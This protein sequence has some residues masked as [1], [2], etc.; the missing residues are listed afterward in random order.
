MNSGSDSPS[1][2]SPP[3]AG[4]TRPAPCYSTGPEIC[5]GPRGARPGAG[6]GRAR[7][8]VGR[9]APRSSGGEYPAPAARGAGA[10]A[11]GA[12]AAPPPGGGESVHERGWSEIF[13]YPVQGRRPKP[14]EQGLTMVIDKGLGLRATQDLLEMA[15]DAIDVIKL[16]FGTPVLYPAERLREKVHLI[17]SY[18]I[19]AYPGGT[20]LEVAVVQGRFQDFLDEAERIGF[21][22][23]EVSDG[24]IPMTPDVRAEII[25]LC[26]ERGFE[27]VSEVGKK[28]PADRVPSTNLVEQVAADLEAGASHVIIEG[29]ESGK[30]VV[31]YQEDGSI[32]DDELEYI[33][34]H[35]PDLSRL[36]WEAP[37]KS[38][39]Q[40]LI[41]RFGPN[42]NLGNV[43]PEDVLACEALRVGLRGDTLRDALLRHPERF[44]FPYLLER[45]G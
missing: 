4:A 31:I 2:L 41:L 6:E 45:E 8:A 35:V 20:L 29:R 43:H 40:D 23:L 30:G 12:A 14:R 9:A 36:I 17:Q 42:V 24:T 37:L 13:P 25:R 3:R 26:R 33:T 5:R 44:P 38:Q 15:A 34:R 10:S 27:V 39:Q 18:G 1:T 21:R 19:P 11:R 16:A 22:R 32:D 7:G 28:H